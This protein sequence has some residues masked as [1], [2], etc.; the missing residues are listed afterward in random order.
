GQGR[1]ATHEAHRLARRRPT[2]AMTTVQRRWLIGIGVIALWCLPG[3]LTELT[4]LLANTSSRLRIQ[5]FMT[6]S[7]SILVWL[8]WAP[9]TPAIAALVRRWPTER[10]NVRNALAVQVPAAI[11]F[12]LFSTLW[13]TAVAKIFAPQERLPRDFWLLFRLY[14]SPRG[15]FGVLLYAA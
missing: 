9:L 8:A 10:G 15:P 5:S 1:C 13:Y 12:A 4:L 14:L 3:I 7:G 6:I 11:A 2:S